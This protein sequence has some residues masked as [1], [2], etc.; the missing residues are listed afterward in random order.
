MRHL[1]RAIALVLVAAVPVAAA[2]PA[3]RPAP[4]GRAAPAGAGPVNINTASA[5]DLMRLDGVGAAL[6]ERIVEYRDKHGPFTKP[7]DLQRVKGVGKGV[8][9][10]NRERIVVK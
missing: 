6:A 1:L 7:D 5:Q 10:K 3:S 9:E 4:S 2:P 8:W